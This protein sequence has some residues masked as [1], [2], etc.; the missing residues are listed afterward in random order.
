MKYIIGTGWWSTS[1][2]TYSEEREKLGDDLI[3]SAEFHKLWY[4]AL[5][6]YTN[7][8]KIIIVDS[9]SP[10]YPPFN[11]S[12]NRI[13]IIS[14]DKNYGHSVDCNSKYSGWMRSCLLGIYYAY[15]CDADYFVYIEQDALIYGKNIIEYAIDKMDKPFMFGDGDN[16][17]QLIQ[18]SFFIIRKDGYIKFLNHIDDINYTDKEIAPETK[19]SSIG[20]KWFPEVFLKNKLGRLF[21]S[22]TNKFRIEYLPFGYGRVRPI[23]WRDNYFYFQHGTVEEIKKY[24]NKT[25]L[26]FKLPI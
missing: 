7:P 1:D 22:L 20:L 21:C 9:N 26:D 2:Y 8:E 15:L 24:L 19:F 12:D 18:Q 16:T 6:E 23:D 4:N 14:L 3:R 17:P 11:K 10:V 25:G 5:C 13:E